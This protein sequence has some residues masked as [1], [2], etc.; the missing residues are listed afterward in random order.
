MKPLASSSFSARM[1]ALRPV[2][3]SAMSVRIDG[4]HE[5]SREFS[6]STKRQSCRRR[7][8]SSARWCLPRSGNATRALRGTHRRT[9]ASCQM[10]GNEST[11]CSYPKRVDEKDSRLERRHTYRREQ[12]QSV[13]DELQG[14][15]KKPSQRFEAIDDLIDDA[16][17]NVHGQLVVSGPRTIECRLDAPIGHRYRSSGTLVVTPL[18]RRVHA[19]IRRGVG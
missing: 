11:Y 9:L 12:V 14:V 2:P 13:V 10:P 6:R 18:V 8:K 15:P 7:K 17:V 1:T 16:L 3:D 5:K 19:A 4:P